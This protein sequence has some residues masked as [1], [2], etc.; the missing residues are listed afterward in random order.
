MKFLNKKVIVTGANRS[1]G[2]EMALAFAQEGA[3]IVISYRNDEAGAKETVAAIEKIG[4]KATAFYADF[5]QMENI[6]AFAEKAIAE[7][8]QVDI[9]I[10]NAGVTSR[11][12]LLDLPPEKMQ[13]T[14]QTNAIAPL[15][16]L[17]LCARSMIEQTIAGCI[18]NISTIASTTTLPRGI[19]YA[20]SKA[21]M[22]KWTQNAALDLAAHSIRVNAIAPGLI[23]AGMNENTETENPQQ[24]ATFLNR[25][26]LGKAGQPRDIVNMALFLASEEANWITGKIIEVDGGQVL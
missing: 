22:N 6:A 9:L 26:P 12:R 2:R 4:Q 7:L 16:L 21:A 24:W 3:D 18:I 17:Q 20:A 11:E 25:I 5:S 13:Q 10:N 23:A 19:V 8:G 1:M 14:F 15:Y